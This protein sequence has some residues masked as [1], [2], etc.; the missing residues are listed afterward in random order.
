MKFRGALGL[1][2]A[3]F[4]LVPIMAG[5]GGDKKS[6]QTAAQGQGSYKLIMTHEVATSHWK[7]KYMEEYGKLVEQRTGGRVKVTLH[8][9][10]QLFTDKQAVE[11]I[12][13]GSVQSVWPVSVN[14]ETVSEKY[15]VIS[16]PF[17]VD[18]EL[19]TT[20]AAFYRKLISFLNTQVDPAKY[21]VLGLL[22]TCEGT[23]IFNKKKVRTP[24]DFKG[25]KIRTIGGQA[26]LD[27]VQAFG[28]SPASM[29]ASEMSQALAQGVI[30]GIN[31]SPSGWSEMIG[32]A[33]RQGLIIPKFQFLTYTVLFDAKWFDSLPQDIQK[34]MQD[35]LEEVLKRQWKE[36]VDLDNESL[37]K[38]KEQLK[39]EIYIVPASE[40]EQWAKASKPVA[41]KFSK[42]FPETFQK[43]VDLNKE[44]SR[45]WPVN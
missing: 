41:E 3:L 30:D 21:K 1:V 24:E 19:M 44:F 10:G 8:P 39:C 14:V 35:T 23:F 36:S 42:K 22:R 28:A 11:S 25:L 20:N 13:T 17:A 6:D 34:I 33:G 40:V 31:S 32:S 4:L 2:C 38:V 37:K 15:G 18:E 43:Y 16:L 5:C 45:K 27:M 12:G 9:A 29:P 26:S 7:H